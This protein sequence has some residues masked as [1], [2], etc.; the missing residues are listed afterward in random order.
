MFYKGILKS[1]KETKP[2][3]DTIRIDGKLASEAKVE[4][5]GNT[6]TTTYKYD[7]VE[8]HVD[9]EVDAVQTHNAQDAIKSAWGVDASGL[10]IL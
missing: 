9:V 10:G 7:G 2:F 1:G 3:A 4:T 6:I 5:K 8:F